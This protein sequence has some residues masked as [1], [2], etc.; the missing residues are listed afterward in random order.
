MRVLFITG[1][2]P[3]MQGGVGDCTNET[4]KALAKL[5][6]EAHVLTK[7]SSPDP[8][9]VFGQKSDSLLKGDV[10]VHRLVGKWNW[11]CLSTISRCVRLLAPEVVHIEYQT[12]AFG[13]HPAVNFLP[14]FLVPRRSNSRV[15]SRRGPV[16]RPLTVTTFHDLKLPYLFPKA[17]PVRAWVTKRLARSSDAVIVTT[18]EDCES[19]RGWGVDNISLIPIGSN[20]PTLPPEGYR[21]AERR[22]HL[23]VA[24]ETTLLCYFGFLNESKGAESL[25]RALSLVRGAMLLMIGGQV[26]ESDPNNIVYLERVKALI[27]Q[28]D[29]TG[30]VIWTGFTPAAEVSANLLASDI[31]VLP[32]RDGVSFR[33]GSFMAALAHGLPIV[34]TSPPSDYSALGNASG[35]RDSSGGIS[36]RLPRLLNEENV[37]LVPPDDPQALSNAIARLASL[38]GLRTRLSR[39]ASELASHFTWGQIAVRHLDFYHQ[40]L[41]SAASGLPLKEP[42][43]QIPS[44]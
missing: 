35:G 9:D 13:M 32:Y 31:C 20:I 25:V 43:D 26:G 4:A 42:S 15:S 8:A 11:S 6:V 30:R 27:D 3:P 29:L 14:R 5:G 40:L 38:P 36:T 12:G 24:P 7:A 44:A 23:G 33:R 19:V 39:G 41:A 18:E 22:E 34:T 2:F 21:R 28:L 37:V 16:A 17:N 10:S 1:E